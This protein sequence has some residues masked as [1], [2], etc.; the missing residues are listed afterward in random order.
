MKKK[1]KCKIK[2]WEFVFLSIG[3]AVLRIIKINFQTEGAVMKKKKKLIKKEKC[4]PEKKKKKLWGM[5][6]V[7][8]DCK[9]RK[10][11]CQIDYFLI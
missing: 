10:R 9:K 1:N 6:G 5:F 4:I 11:K 8:F 2:G 7:V 3:W